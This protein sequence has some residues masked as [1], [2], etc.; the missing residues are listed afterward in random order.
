MTGD[1]ILQLVAAVLGSGGIVATVLTYFNSRKQAQTDADKVK[2]DMHASDSD[3]AIRLGQN[4]FNISQ[5]LQGQLRK[6]I[7]DLR[8]IVDDLYAQNRKLLEENNKLLE[9]NRGL[10]EENNKLLRENKNLQADKQELIDKL[11]AGAKT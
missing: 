5:E 2:S 4:A 11:Q 10:L 6:D 3:A 9:A 7:V 8:A 1:T